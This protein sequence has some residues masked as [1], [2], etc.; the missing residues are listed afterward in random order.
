VTKIWQKENVQKNTNYYIVVI[1]QRVFHWI[2][3]A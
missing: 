2:R 3:E 1:L